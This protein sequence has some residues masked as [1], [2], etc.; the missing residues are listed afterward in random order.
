MA[1]NPQSVI[2]RGELPPELC[3]GADAARILDTTA[4]SI[5]R[6]VH[7]GYLPPVQFATGSGG[8]HIFDRAMVEELAAKRRAALRVL[9]IRTT[10]WQRVA[11]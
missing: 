7:S 6:Y 3:D 4:T 2:I 11:L 1:S 10:E 8:R 9:D 5:H